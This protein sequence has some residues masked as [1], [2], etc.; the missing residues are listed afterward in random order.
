ML[1]IWYLSK[2]K[3]TNG[4]SS[5]NQSF[6][7]ENQCTWQ[8]LNTKWLNYTSSS[9]RSS[10]KGT[11][12]SYTQIKHFLFNPVFSQNFTR[13]VLSQNLQR[14]KA[15]GK[16]TRS[17]TRKANKA[18]VSLHTHRSSLCDINAN[19]ITCFLPDQ[20]KLGGVTA[21]LVPPRLCLSY[22]ELLPVPHLPS[23]LNR[24]RNGSMVRKASLASRVAPGFGH[25]AQET[26]AHVASFSP[27]VS[28]IVCSES[29]QSLSLSHLL[30]DHLC[31]TGL[32]RIAHQPQAFARPVRANYTRYKGC[33]LISHAI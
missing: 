29:Y 13:T 21:T 6:K 7:S 20:D 28:G 4:D 12:C 1:I 31:F 10:R 30:M 32:P 23:W 8:L 33:I 25:S 27:G 3:C 22:A 14:Q 5:K 2:I 16:K 9:S 19:P 17:S 15:E 26:C 11:P 18:N 24:G